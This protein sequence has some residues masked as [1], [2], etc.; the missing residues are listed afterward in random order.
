MTFAPAALHDYIGAVLAADLDPES[1]AVVVVMRYHADESGTVYL[2]K[3]EIAAAAKLG[4]TTAFQRLANLAVRKIVRPLRT[5]N[6]GSV[7]QLATPDEIRFAVRAADGGVRAADGIVRQTDGTVRAA[8]GTV[9]AADGMSSPG[10]RQ[11]HIGSYSGY[12]V[13]KNDDEG[14]VV[15]AAVAPADPATIATSTHDEPHDEAAKKLQGHPAKD[16]LLPFARAALEI[17]GVVPE[18]Y[19]LESW[20][21][22]GFTLPR[23]VYGL[24]GARQAA[25]GVHINPGKIILSAGRWMQNA[26]PEEWQERPQEARKGAETGQPIS[27]PPE[28]A[29][30][31]LTPE[32]TAAMLAEVLG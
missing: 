22:R 28:V 3:M 25:V 4:R 10:E 15:G 16:Q 32:E 26:R 1:L 19:T 11:D 5:S 2:T 14:E 13:N 6:R 31:P 7:Y 29:R 12:D 24:R 21:M 30:K 17:A 27:T 23:V 18:V 9:R 20:L 8:D